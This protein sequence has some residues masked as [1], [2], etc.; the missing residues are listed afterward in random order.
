MI[1]QRLQE[2]NVPVIIEGYNLKEDSQYN[3]LKSN[4]ESIRSGLY[5]QS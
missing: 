4:N 1:V 5:Y 2:I 3:K